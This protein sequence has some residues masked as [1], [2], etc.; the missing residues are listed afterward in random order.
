MRWC[1]LV[2][3][4]LTA[5]RP[6]AAQK[7]A[8]PYEATVEADDAFVRSGPGSKYYPTG[9]LK[10]GQTVV[11]QRHDPGGW[12]M[13]APPAGSFS[14][15]KARYVDKGAADRGTVNANNVVVWVGSFESDI[16][17]VFQRKLAQGDEVRILGEKQLT[18]ETADGSAELWYRIA[19]P[20][21]EWRWIAGQAISPPPRDLSAVTGE[22]PFPN[23]STPAASPRAV[24]A[25]PPIEGDSDGFAKPL[26]AGNARDYLDNDSGAAASRGSAGNRDDRD[27]IVERPVVRRQ[28]QGAPAAQPRSTS[29]TPRRLEAQLEELDQLDVRFRAILDKEPLEWDFSQL[30][31]DYRALRSEVD[32]ANTQQMIDVRLARIRDHQKTRAEHEELARM[33]QE[34]LKRDAELAEIQRRHEAKLTTLQQPRFD[35]AGI[36]QRSALNRKGAPPYVLLALNGRVLAYL[37]PAPGVSLEPWVGRSVGVNGSRIPHPDLK[38]D[39]ITVTRLAPVR[40]AK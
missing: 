2:L 9:K 30:E 36:V 11:V 37:V 19:P 28:K 3:M 7:P 29:R 26:P 22:G 38:A 13:I 27:D 17:D 34:T 31:Q 21:G 24:P 10:R 4:V 6:A 40:L 20:R 23:R 16:R 8:F 15:V 39:L 5:A 18:P 1:L 14:W 33:A 32:S 35:G 12:H 25:V